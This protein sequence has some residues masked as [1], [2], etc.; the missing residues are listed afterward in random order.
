MSL[1]ELYDKAH[2]LIKHSQSALH[3]HPAYKA[4]RSLPEDRQKVVAIAAATT[5][6]LFVFGLM[7]AYNRMVLLGLIASLLAGSATGL[8]ALPTLFFKEI[9]DKLLSIMLGGAAGVMLAATAFSLVVPGIDYGNLL[10][11]GKGIYAMAFGMM[12]GILFLH[13]ADQWLPH[14]HVGVMV[15]PE[16]SRSLRKIW[17]FVIA[18]TIHNFPEGWRSA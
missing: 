17:L 5:A 7:Y 9:S 1:P 12:I 10:W 11:P 18:I 3:R 13:Y 14:D 2:R 16:R 15:P 8:G 6:V 4:F